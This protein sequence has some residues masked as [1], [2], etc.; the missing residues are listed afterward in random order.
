MAKGYVIASID[1]ADQGAYDAYRS[2]TPDVIAQ[3]GGRF[4]VRGGTVTPLEGEMGLKGRLVILEFPSVEAARR[5]Y[6]SPEYQ[7]IIPLRTR[8]SQGALLIVE[9]FDPPTG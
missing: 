9:G 4:L 8:A 3:Y 6:D 2:R 5:F 1:V 7:E